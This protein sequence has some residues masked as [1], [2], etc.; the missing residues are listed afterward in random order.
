MTYDH[1]PPL[2]H[3]EG[4]M[5]KGNKLGALQLLNFVTTSPP[6]PRYILQNS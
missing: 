3:L 1:K 5:E 6:N 2:D 4:Y